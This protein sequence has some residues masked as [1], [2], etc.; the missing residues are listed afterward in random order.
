MR[1]D[2]VIDLDLPLQGCADYVRSL[3]AGSMPEA[4]GLRLEGDAARTVDQ[5]W[6]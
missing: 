3:L 1:M 6:W 2:V 4:G 5:Q